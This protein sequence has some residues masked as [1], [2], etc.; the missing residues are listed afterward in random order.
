MGKSTGVNC[1]QV[2]EGKGTKTGVSDKTH[3]QCDVMVKG[4]LQGNNRQ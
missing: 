1:L 2:A 3:L 4:V